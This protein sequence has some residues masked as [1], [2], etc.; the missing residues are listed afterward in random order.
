MVHSHTGTKYDEPGGGATSPDFPWPAYELLRD[1]NNVFSALFAYQPA[2][3]L[4]LMVRGQAELGEVEFVSGNFFNG[5]GIVPA[6]G[7]LI[8]DS[9]NTANASQV[10]VISYSYWQTRFGGE[11]SAI[12]QAIRISNIPFTITG[13]AAPEFFGVKPGSAPMVYVPIASRPV[14]ARN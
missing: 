7:R 1:H 11:S 3:R 2:G 13:V 8:T 12:G 6:A 14:L 9:D 10:G 4:D 5:L